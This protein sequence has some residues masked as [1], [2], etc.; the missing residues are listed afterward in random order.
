M[1]RTGIALIG[2]AFL[3]LLAVSGH[4]YIRTQ[5]IDAAMQNQVM[6]ALRELKQLD[7]DW[8]TNILMARAGMHN[9]YD[10]LS[11]P[12]P[13]VRA[14]RE[15][16]AIRVKMAHSGLLQEPFDSMERAFVTK[17]D[18][19]EQFKSHNALLQNSLRYFP[20]A[21]EAFKALLASMPQADGRAA[22]AR[23]DA[24][25]EGLLSDILRFNLQPEAQLGKEISR[26]LDSL[27]NNRGDYPDA[28]LEP[29]QLL[30]RHARITLRQRLLE[31]ALM[32]RIAGTPTAQAID[33]LS[34]AFDE[35]FQGMLEQKQHYR[36]Y[37]FLYS[38][39]LLLLLAYVA[40]RLL[41][42]YR[43][44]A[45][46]NRHLHIANETLEQRVAERT[47]ELERQSA[48]L[49]ELATHDMLT[50]LVNRRHLMTQLSDSLQ[51]AE[52]RDWVVA[53]M[54]IDLDGF[55]AIND[56][57]GHATGDLLLQE[58][59]ARLDRHVRKEDTF[60]RLG[61]DEFVILLNQTSAP[62]GAIRVAQAVLQELCALRRIE[63]HA[64]YISA[65]IG[66]SSLRGAANLEQAPEW[67]LKQADQAMYLAKQQGKN[68]YC[69]SMPHA[70]S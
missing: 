23:H 35:E 57:Y 47:A 65:S 24:A 60:A 19:V 36:N 12:L 13:H 16:L 8:N 40:W 20:T 59:A 61:G 28:L 62:E 46:V 15:R 52:R 27:D 26:A 64:V 39:F 21:M 38:G 67:L 4:L 30:T 17:E 41:H 32:T 66:I 54:F 53:L 45:Q 6:A 58:V 5:A 44:I 1:K 22:N 68:R 70:W 51:R 56:S 2:A 31:D 69:L 33:T 10:P 34:D 3:A 49:E 63:G 37:L 42:S 48:Q 14:L 7:A 9:N 11:A 50:G 43:T 29:L 55:K 18:L 25:T